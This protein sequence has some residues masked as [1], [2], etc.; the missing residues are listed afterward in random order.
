[1]KGKKGQ[2]RAQEETDRKIFGFS[3]MLQR[4]PR[5]QL[6]SF[7]VLSEPSASKQPFTQTISLETTLSSG[8]V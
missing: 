2:T 3:L 5:L 7:Q 4:L 8:I 1:M 6:I